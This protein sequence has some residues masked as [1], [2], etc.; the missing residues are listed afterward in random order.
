MNTGTTAID[1]SGMYP[2]D[3]AEP[4]KWQFPTGTTIAAAGIC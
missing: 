3:R 4:K 1:L 2:D